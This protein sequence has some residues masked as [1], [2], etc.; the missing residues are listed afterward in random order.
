MNIASLPEDLLVFTIFKYLSSKN[1]FVLRLVCRDWREHVRCVWC[2]VVKDEM[3]DQLH[4]LDLVYEKETLEKTLAFKLRYLR[5]YATLM[6]KYFAH[7]RLSDLTAR[8]QTAGPHLKIVTL[9]SC[10]LLNSSVCTWKEAVIFIYSGLFS[11][12][13]QLF[14]DMLTPPI[15]SL[16]EVRKLRTELPA[17][18]E[19]EECGVTL[20]LHSWLDGA[21]EFSTLKHE[22]CELEL[23]H[24]R[25]VERIKE[26]SQLWPAKKRF[27]ERGYKVLLVSKLRSAGVL[28]EGATTMEQ[29]QELLSKLAEEEKTEDSE[30]QT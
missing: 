8:I 9:I 19:G 22:I 14:T 2:Q 3:I 6:Q 13:L 23:Q 15:R 27:I 25:V 16:D 21:L 29:I 26:V 24:E 10:Y 18:P 5:S 17:L 12:S 28:R 20:L 4:N 1:L 30:T 7:I 11:I